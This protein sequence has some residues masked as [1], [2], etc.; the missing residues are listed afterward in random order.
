MVPG[1]LSI[2][3]NEM[4]RITLHIPLL[5][6]KI[7]PI[8]P[9]SAELVPDAKATSAGSEAKKNYLGPLVSTISQN[10]KH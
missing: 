8:L 1:V 9:F 10:G 4:S 3:L 6:N 5:K 7:V 2:L